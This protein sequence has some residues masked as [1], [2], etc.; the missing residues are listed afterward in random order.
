MCVLAA[1]ECVSYSPSVAYRVPAESTPTPKPTQDY[2]PTIT[3]SEVPNS[4]TLISIDK[5]GDGKVLVNW[6]ATGSFPKGFKIVYSSY[7]TSPIWPGDEFVYVSD[8]NALSALVSGLRV[9][10]TYYFR[11]CKFN[12]MGCDFYSNMKTYTVP[13]YT[14]TKT[15][16]P[17]VDSSSIDLNSLID[18]GGG[19]VQVNWVSSG[20]FPDGFKVVWSDVTTTPVFPG[21]D[22]VLLSNPAATT[23]IISGLTDGTTYYFRVCRLSG[24]ICDVY[25]NMESFD[26]PVPTSTPT[27]T[28]EP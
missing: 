12:G 18:Q 4:L 16:S 28:P 21:N 20:S 10:E 6:S 23:T 2:S 27:L 17:T 8:Q 22:N 13:D 3:P 11:V 15:P 14:V 1:D 26:V 5:E 25:S 24:E 9:N 7:N 19:S